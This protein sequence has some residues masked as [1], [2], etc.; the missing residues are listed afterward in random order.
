VSSI[1]DTNHELLT[2]RNLGTYEPW[3][4]AELEDQRGARSRA[5]TPSLPDEL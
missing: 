3:A 5:P 2:Y 1:D 4:I